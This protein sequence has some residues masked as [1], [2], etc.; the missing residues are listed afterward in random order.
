M[1]T[2]PVLDA[3]GAYPIAVLQ[4]KARAMAEAGETLI[5]FSI[6]DPNEPT[7]EFIRQALKAAVPD[8]SRYPTVPGL[9][10]LREIF[11]GYLLRR[12][13]VAVD[14]GTQILP[15]T[16]SK[17]AIFS[18]PL[19][20]IEPGAGE[21]VLWPSPGY[22]IYERGTRLAG[23]DSVPIELAGDFV[24]RPGDI[25]Q[26]QWESARLLWVNYPH[27]PTGAVATAEALQELYGAARASSVLVCSDECYV[28]IFEGSPPA[29][30]LQVAREGATGLLAYFSLSKRS[31]M[32]GYRSGMV[33]GDAEAIDA[34][35][36]LRSSTG[37]APAEF[38]QAAATAA[39]ADDDHVAE[40]RKIFAEKRAV[41]AEAFESMGYEAVGSQ[42][43][44]YLWVKV[45]DDVEVADKLLKSGVV[46]SPGR[47]FGA[48]GEGFLRL[49]LVP[50]VGECVAAVEVL[51][52]CLT[53]I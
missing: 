43:A 28:D 17:E 52:T 12:F 53:A 3:L 11:A 6:G 7:P 10:E 37:T 35:R 8:V 34:L 29:S 23:A 51:R 49:A 42:A 50:T 14:P 40:R 44:I 33:V 38:V 21:A 2:N 9:P 31:G 20:F 13:G 18:T 30:M 32:T 19:A 25:S 26:A 1:R 5:D 15:T 45:D 4:E 48:G 46:V 22:P 27:N 24:M 16:G 39:W 47:G 36:E 41:L